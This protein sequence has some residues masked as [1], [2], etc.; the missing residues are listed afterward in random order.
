MYNR[1]D[2]YRSFRIHQQNVECIGMSAEGGAKIFI[3][4]ITRPCNDNIPMNFFA[5]GIFPQISEKCSKTVMDS[6]NRIFSI[7]IVM[8]DIINY[9]FLFSILIEENTI[10]QSTSIARKRD[11]MGKII[12]DEEEF[13]IN[14]EL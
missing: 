12:K 11:K 5:S 14:A 2:G 4:K 8:N 1:I 10:N 9:L 6:P 7:S 3:G 13:R